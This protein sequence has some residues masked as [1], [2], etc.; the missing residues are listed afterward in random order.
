[1]EFFERLINKLEVRLLAILGFHTNLERQLM[2][3]SEQLKAAQVA[4]SASSAGLN[5]KVDGL[6]TAFTTA[7]TSLAALIAAGA[8]DTVS[9]VDAQSVVDN[10][11]ADAAAAN[12]EGDRVAAA[13]AAAAAPAPSPAPAPAVGTDPVAGDAG[14]ATT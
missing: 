14:A 2:S 7:T 13:I 4:S 8:G 3:I 9:K 1:M 5:A 6:L 11:T 12:A 10:L